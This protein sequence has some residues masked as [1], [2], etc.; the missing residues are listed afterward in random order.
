[1]TRTNH[2]P[3]TRT[4]HWI[5]AIAVAAAYAVAVV[6]EE[7]PKGDFRSFLLGLHMWIGMAVVAL[8]VV[9][10]VWRAAAPA[11]TPAPGTPTT[12]LAAKAAHL[13]LYAALILLPVVGLLAAWGKGR[14]VTLFGLMPLMLPISI[15]RETG[16]RLEDLHGLV[17]HAVMILAGLH[18]AAAIAHQWVL[19]DGTLGRMLPFVRGPETSAAE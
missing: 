19:K 9:R 17:G 1:M 15:D 18:A 11:V 16:G 14:S 3:L 10:L 8:S 7:L 12:R 4:I 13:A 6:R 2:D 5:V